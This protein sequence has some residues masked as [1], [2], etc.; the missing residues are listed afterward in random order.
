[1]KKLYSLVDNNY[2]Q[3][4]QEYERLWYSNCITSDDKVMIIAYSNW[5][6]DNTGLSKEFLENK[7]H[8]KYILK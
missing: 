5:T 4:V 1:M 8:T 2:N 6:F 7:W 3:L